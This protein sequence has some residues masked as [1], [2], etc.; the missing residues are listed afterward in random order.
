LL[1]SALMPVEFLFS[2]VDLEDRRDDGSEGLAV[3][4][5]GFGLKV[6]FGFYLFDKLPNANIRFFPGQLGPVARNGG[7]PALSLENQKDVSGLGGSRISIRGS[8]APFVPAPAVLDVNRQ[9]R[10]FVLVTAARVDGSKNPLFPVAE[11]GLR[12]SSARMRLHTTCTFL[13]F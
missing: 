10:G 7:V 1:V 13:G 4:L 9:V 8:Q 2:A 12:K 11:I 6:C 5:N 3:P